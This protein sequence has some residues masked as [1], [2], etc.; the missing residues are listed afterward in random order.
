MIKAPLNDRK[1][2][3]SCP[4]GILQAMI[5][6]NR[7]M[8]LQWPTLN[9]YQT[10]ISRMTTLAAAF[11]I[12]LGL[13]GCTQEEPLL[14]LPPRAIQWARVSDAT[15]EARRVISGI[16][17][18]VSDTRLAFEVNGV[19]ATVDVNFGDIVKSGQILATLD[20]EPLR[21]TVRDAEA[22]LASIRADFQDATLTYERAK[23]LFKEN[24]AS[25]AERDRAKARFDSTRSGVDAA[26]ARL[27]LAQRDLRRSALRAPFD[28][29]ISVRNIDPAQKVTL[30]ETAFEM[31]SGESGLR[32]EVQVPETVIARVKQGQEVNVRLPSVSA[33]LYPAVVSEVGTRASGGNAFTVKADLIQPVKSARPGMTAEV[34]FVYSKASGLLDFDGVVIPMAS[35]RQD[36]DGRMSVFV[37]DRASSTLKQTTIVTGGVLYNEIA[38][39]DGLNDDDIIATAGVSFLTDGKTVRLLE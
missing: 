18:A 36:M 3:F 16:V 33:D 39:T 29:S 10:T 26:E 15:G 28:G 20:P 27:G 11:S 7:K 2:E 21:L 4:S 17:T 9:T 35:V 6:G 1:G 13:V 31:D 38:V 30:G 8:S 12:S 14:E 34:H 32:V 25:A 5:E 23:A 22:Q 19:V 24:V 37:F